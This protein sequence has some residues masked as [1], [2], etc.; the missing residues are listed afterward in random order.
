MSN[1]IS[2]A[3]KNTFNFFQDVSI[4][5]ENTTG[6]NL[7]SALKIAS[8]FVLI[9]FLYEGVKYAISSFSSLN[10]RVSQIDEQLD[11]EL[12]EFFK[13]STKTDK[14]FVIEGQD[15]WII[16]NPEQERMFVRDEFYSEAGVHETTVKVLI[17][18]SLSNK[19]VTNAI[20]TK[21]PPNCITYRSYPRSASIYSW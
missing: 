19:S 5:Y 3:Y 14:T 18:S 13:S 15:V 17:F 4:S 8:C 1:L 6:K 12:E 16:F 21:L 9:A 7:S 2:A 11:N 20:L 10:G